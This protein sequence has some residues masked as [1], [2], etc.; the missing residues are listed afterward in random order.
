MWKLF[1]KA[2]KAPQREEFAQAIINGLGRVSGSSDATFN[3]ADFQVSFR[4]NHLHLEPGYKAYCESPPEARERILLQVIKMLLEKVSFPATWDQAASQVLPKVIS[5]VNFQA[6]VG[7]TGRMPA[8]PI[9]NEL[10][11]TLV[12]DLPEQMLFVTEEQLQKWSVVPE[13]AFEKAKSNL[14]SSLQTQFKQA[15]PGLHVIESSDLHAPAR[16]LYPDLFEQL[17]TNGEPIVLPIDRQTIVVT[18]ASDERA[19][20]VMF[21]Q[22]TAMLE[23]NYLCLAVPLVLRGSEWTSAELTSTT[24]KR[25]AET[26]RALQ[27]NEQKSILDRLHTLQKCDVNVSSAQLMAAPGD[28]MLS[29]TVCPIGVIS[30]VPKMDQ[31]WLGREVGAEVEF[32]KLPWERAVEILELEPIDQVWPERYRVHVAWSPDVWAQLSEFN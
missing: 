23:N 13:A 8:H 28:S 31:L 4:G 24:A 16:L 22:A 26:I 3:A 6:M 29:F 21:R 7:V 18:G 10:V 5:R 25:F 11:V 1:S 19:L 12:L 9:G 20:E 15:I 14:Q 30:W 27:Y 32:C 17:Q 2:P